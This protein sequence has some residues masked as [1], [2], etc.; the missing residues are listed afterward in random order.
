[1]YNWIQE[2]SLIY[3][4]Q[5]ESI[6]WPLPISIQFTM[7][8]CSYSYQGV[9]SILHTL[10]IYADVANCCGQENVVEIIVCQLWL[11]NSRAPIWF[12]SLSWNPGIPMWTS[13]NQ[14]DGG[15]ETTARRGQLWKLKPP[16]TTIQAANPIYV[17]GF[18]HDQQNYWHISTLMGC[19][20]IL[21]NKNKCL[22]F[23]ATEF[24]VVLLCNS[25]HTQ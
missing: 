10:W 15:W 3:W 7:G 24:W 9:E 17:K 16:C 23:Q 14:P 18:S 22:L 11:S 1:M 8:L 19:I 13:P 6:S 5:S 2:W 4:W 20:N 25:C 12:C 21:M